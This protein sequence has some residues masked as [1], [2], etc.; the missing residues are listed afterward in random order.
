MLRRFLRRWRC[1]LGHCPGRV[2]SGWRGGAL[3]IGYACN[4]CGKV[5]GY[6]PVIP[7]HW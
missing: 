3:C 6:G 7:R 5:T 2:V 1:R 4:D